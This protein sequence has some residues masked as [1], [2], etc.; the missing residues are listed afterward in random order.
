MFECEN[1]RHPSPH[2]MAA[3]DRLVKLQ[4]IEYRRSVVGEHL[5]RIVRR[6]LA[7]LSHSTIV[8]SDYGVIAG[9]LGHLVDFPNFSVARCFT[10]KEKRRSVPMDL[11]VDVCIFELP[12]RHDKPP[13][14]NVV[15]NCTLAS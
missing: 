15:P 12:D 6:R 11:V 3:N 1:L 2:R 5:H 8:E 7:G 4:M 9:K 10:E 13:R 14:S